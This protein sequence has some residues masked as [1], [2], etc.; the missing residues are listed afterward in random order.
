MKNKSI[1]VILLM[2]FVFSCNKAST[3][4]ES[5]VDIAWQGGSQ[6]TYRYS[7]GVLAGCNWYSYF[8]VID[9]SGDI[10]FKV[11]VNGSKKK[12]ETFTVEE[13][14]QYII[15]V[16]FSVSGCTGQSTSS[17]AE[18]KSSSVNNSKKLSV[19]CSSISISDISLSEN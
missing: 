18:L 12:T 14:I 19:D 17:N 9:G 10:T 13:G 2:L 15:I 7:T 5:N 3:N 8:D 11:Y 4:S 16:S 6:L 1:L